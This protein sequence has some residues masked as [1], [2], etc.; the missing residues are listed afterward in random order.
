MSNGKK[1]AFTLYLL[2][3]DNKELKFCND[4]VPVVEVLI[5]A[6]PPLLVMSLELAKSILP[7]L[8]KS[9]DNTFFAVG[10]AGITPVIAK[11]VANVLELITPA[12]A[13]FRNT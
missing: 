7:S 9:A 11:L 2:V 4:G 8:F 3:E 12:V 6:K 1:E 10:D 5:L 13:V